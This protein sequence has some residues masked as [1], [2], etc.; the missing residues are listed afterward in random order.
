MQW[1][2]CGMRNTYTHPESSAA[3]PRHDLN[4]RER[5]LKKC[6]DKEK[7]SSGADLKDKYN[8]I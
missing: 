2:T 6:Q 4:K 3:S 1:S 8:S 5:E 7:A